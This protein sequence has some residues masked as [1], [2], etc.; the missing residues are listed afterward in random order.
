MHFFC[1]YLLDK[2]L[3]LSIEKNQQLNNNNSN[4]KY[5]WSCSSLTFKILTKYATQ[6]I[7]HWLVGWRVKTTKN[8]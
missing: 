8:G 2:E 6:K 3:W 7:N 1:L 5:I 4:D